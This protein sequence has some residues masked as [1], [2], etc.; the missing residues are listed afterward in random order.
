MENVSGIFPSFQWNISWKM[1]GIF[2][3]VPNGKKYS[4]NANGTFLKSSEFL[5]SNI[6]G[7]ILKKFPNFGKKFRNIKEIFF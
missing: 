6:P 7:R 1:C 5:N 4:R 2:L 3:I